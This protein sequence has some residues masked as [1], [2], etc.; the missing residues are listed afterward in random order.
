M[1]NAYINDYHE[2][3]KYHDRLTQMDPV[4]LPYDLT[5]STMTIVCKIPIVF[6]VITIANT[7]ELSMECIHMVK[8]GNNGEI[9]RTILPTKYVNKNTKKITANTPKNFYNQVSIQI[10]CDDI[11]RMNIKLFKNGSIQ[12]TG[13]KNISSVIWALDVLFKKFKDVM[14]NNL[15]Y[16][17]PHIFLDILNIYDLRIAMINSN[18]DIGFR[19]DR[20]K[21]FVL[22]RSDGYECTYDPSRHAG[23]NIRYNSRINEQ[24]NISSIFVFDGGSVIIT[25][26][27]NYLQLIE[28]Y[29]F[30]N[31]YLI[32][33]YTKIVRILIE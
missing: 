3:M 15:K 20:E 23:V 6:D 26:S 10:N 18:F 16:A 8:C 30:I 24:D 9:F 2:F 14:N 5:V 12:I 22:L 19:V 13:C 32:E 31:K 21:L 11:I 27:R 33:N 7:L 1:T 25:G 17:E 4:G 28:C 29:K